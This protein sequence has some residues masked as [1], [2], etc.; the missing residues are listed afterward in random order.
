MMS[1]IGKEA[2]KSNGF[3]MF[4]CGVIILG[5][6]QSYCNSITSF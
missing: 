2:L 5:L 6:L 3:G 1:C 4:G